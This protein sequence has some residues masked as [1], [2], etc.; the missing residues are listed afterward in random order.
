MLFDLSIHNPTERPGAAVRDTRQDIPRGTEPG[1]RIVRIAAGRA[2][3]S[4]VRT[5]RISIAGISVHMDV[6]L[7]RS[8]VRHL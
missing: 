3:R 4:S 8:C 7:E 2:P 1:I 5:N 6:R